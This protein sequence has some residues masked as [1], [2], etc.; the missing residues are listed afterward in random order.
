MILRLSRDGN[1]YG[2]MA[3]WAGDCECGVGW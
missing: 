1:N 2:A 3:V